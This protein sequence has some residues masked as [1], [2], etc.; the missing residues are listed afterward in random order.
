MRS[1]ALIQRRSWVLRSP[2]TPSPFV[3]LIRGVQ[4]SGAERW[5]LLPNENATI[6]FATRLAA[7]LPQ[8]GSPLVLY[9]HGETLCFIAYDQ[10]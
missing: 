2:L 5:R 9:L 7:E 4:L 3:S 6:G 10:G 1:Q 8:D